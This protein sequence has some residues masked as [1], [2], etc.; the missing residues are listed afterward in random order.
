MKLYLHIHTYVQ[1]FTCCV[2]KKS[3]RPLRNLKLHLHT[4]TRERLFTCDVCKKSVKQ[5]GTLKLH[6]HAH[7]EECP[8]ICAV[9]KK[10]FKQPNALKINLHIDTG[11]WPFTVVFVGNI[12][13]SLVPRRCT[14]TLIHSGSL[15]VICARIQWWCPMYWM[16]EAL[17]LANNLQS[18]FGM[19][20]LF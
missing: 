17:N 7:N 5:S 19:T 3:F 16:F 8:F 12:S 10:Y 4:D 6:L 13:S 18:W 9:C 1:P 2:C 20:K 11:G 14:Y 15:Y